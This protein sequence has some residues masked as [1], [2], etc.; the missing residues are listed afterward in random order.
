MADAQRSADGAYHYAAEPTHGSDSLDSMSLRSKDV[1]GYGDGRDTQE[2]PEQRVNQV[3]RFS[4]VRE[5]S[6]RSI[7]RYIQHA[8]QAGQ[9]LDDNRE[10]Q[11]HP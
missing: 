11:G 2:C 4:P 6:V 10:Q 5:P 1:D 9:E 8:D 3:D 7:E